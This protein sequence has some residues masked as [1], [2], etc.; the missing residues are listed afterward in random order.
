[1]LPPLPTSAGAAR[2]FLRD[3]LNDW[4]YPLALGEIPCLLVTEL[5]TNAI[6]HTGTAVGLEVRL[7]GRRLGIVVSDGSTR[8]PVPRRCGPSDDSGRG[9]QL[10]EELA[11]VWGIETTATGKAV[12]FEVDLEARERLRWRPGG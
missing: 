6:I 4:G 5:V 9:L 11:E 7:E 10:V 1:V 2:R 12:W 3:R 8:T